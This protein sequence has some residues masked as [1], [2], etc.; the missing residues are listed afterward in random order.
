[1]KV[2]PFTQQ[3]SVLSEK[4]AT[5]LLIMGNPN[6]GK[7]ALF[8]RLTGRHHK[9]GNFPGVTVEKKTGYLR[10]H[11]I[12]ID[13]LPGSYSLKPQSFDE[14]IVTDIVNSWRSEHQRP[15]GL[16]LV[17]DATNFSRTIFF[18]LQL[19]EWGIPCVLAVNMID[20]ARRQGIQIDAEKIRT[21]LGLHAVICT[22]AKTGEGLVEL[23]REIKKL[24][25]EVHTRIKNR[26]VLLNP[27]EKLSLIDELVR[28]LAGKE[29]RLHL[30]PVIDAIRLVEDDLYME[31]LSEYLS[32]SEQSEIQKR[33][34][35]LR[36]SL[37]L[38]G[39]IHTSLESDLRYRFI[40]QEL[41]PAPMQ[42]PAEQTDLSERIDRIFT[43]P[44]WGF[45]I[46]LTVMGFIFNAIF[47]WAAYPMALIETGILKVSQLMGPLL[48][49]GMLKSLIIDGILA[50]VGNVVVFLPQ[51]LLLIFFLGILED[52]GYMSR[53]SFIMDRIMK[54][55]GL[56]GKSVLPMLS[57]FACAIPATMAA[58]TIDNWHER[59]KLILLIPLMSCSARLPVY[60][61]LISAFVPSRP[62]FGIVNLQGA[63]LFAV[64]IL[65]FLTALLIAFLLRF[66]RETKP[67]YQFIMELPP[68]RIPLIQ[69]LWWRIYD[70]GKIF[71][72][73]AGSIILAVSILLWFL[74][75]NPGPDSADAVKA[76]G[77][78]Q[79]YIGS[80]GKFIEPV[81]RPLGFDW[82]I[83]VGLIT[84]FAAREVII[85]TLATIYNI[86]DQENESLIPVKEAMIA[87][88]YPDGR[89]VFT[90]LVALS[91]IV[92]FVYAAQCM[93]TFAVVR[94]ET[95]SWKWPFVMVVYMNLLAYLAALIVFQGG[96]LIGL[97]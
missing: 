28:I 23:I 90:P 80:A 93:S 1:L 44:V 6:S 78:E 53:I 16:I 49:E 64:Y 4:S 31:A 71:V 77:V 58:R 83:G 18:V 32:E 95:N 34:K 74:A 8:N 92:F 72:F 17:A 76:V 19:I 73:N 37:H 40:D 60:T 41:I 45:V 82:K 43:H 75:S 7:T 30:N 11:N 14:K 87:D 94:R 89:P 22:S 46:M 55:F 66:R 59:L 35:E 12:A 51:I 27:D 5:R 13:D 24:S 38:H 3:Q 47:T 96:K 85:S 57:G 52:S 29:E 9:S 39:I 70:A 36:K 81:I 91:L 25:T 54:K 88:R 50:G 10:D 61:L 67:G 56:H 62:L 20:E 33:V 15:D 21:R 97:E 69:S 26:P 65:G 84:S 2:T 42:N 86:D 48:P 63:V 79:S 68:Y